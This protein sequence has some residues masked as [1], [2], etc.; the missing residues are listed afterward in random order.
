MTTHRFERS[1]AGRDTATQRGGPTLLFL[2]DCCPTPGARVE[3]AADAPFV[4][5]LEC[6][7]A[8]ERPAPDKIVLVLDDLDLEGCFGALP[9]AVNLANNHSADGG[10][11]GFGRLVEALLS[12]GVAF[13]G[14]GL[15]SERWCNPASVT[16]AGRAVR[17]FGYCARKTAPASG[18]S[19]GPAPLDLDLVRSDLRQT[20]GDGAYKVVCVHWGIEEAFVPRWQDYEMARAI[21]RAGADA[22]VGSHPHCVQ[23]VVDLDGSVVAFSLGNTC[24]GDLDL[25]ADYDEDRVP[26][27]RFRKRQ[28]PWNRQSIAL[29]INPATGNRTVWPMI[30]R[31]ATTR[32]GRGRYHRLADIDPFGGRALYDRMA[33]ADRVGRARRGM[34]ARFLARPHLPKPSTLLSA[35]GLRRGRGA[36]GA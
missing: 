18:S 21:A 19:V 7:L 32:R 16:I 26:R 8:G 25:A 10:E 22:V 23:P 28:M 2:G 15:A 11:D 31:G 1:P 27:R 13:F 35:L 20:E 9:V 29:E 12:C 17:L 30:Q 14:A 24:F 34:V 5:N 4:I 33:E 3:L 6:C 36:G